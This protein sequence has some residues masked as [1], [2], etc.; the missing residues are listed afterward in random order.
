MFL[1]KTLMLFLLLT[2]LYAYDKEA[3]DTQSA[4]VFMYHRFGESAYPSTNIKVEQFAFH[5]EYLQKNDYNVWPLSK[6]IRYIIEKK[7]LPKKTV[8]LTIDDAYKSTYTHA[9]PM[10]KKKNF[11]F[12]VFVN[13][14]PVDQKSKSFMSWDQIREMRQN[15]AEFLNH[16]FSHDYL[17]PKKG[18]SEDGWKKRIG[19]EVQKAQKR[20]Q[21]E[22]GSDTNENPKILSYPFGEYSEQS[23]ELIASLGYIG[24]TQASGVMGHESD[25]KALC[26][27]PMA[28]DFAHAESFITK[29]NTLPLPV[30]SVHPFDPLLKAE[31]PPTLRIKLKRPLSQLG[32]YIASGEAIKVHWISQTEFEV[33][34]NRPLEAPRNRYACTAPAGEGKWYWFSHLWIIN[35]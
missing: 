32:C 6:V 8:S 26:R 33:R 30:E 24:V 19:D 34:A 4:V 18:E 31:N 14:A 10:L 9:Y 3:A 16:S 29:L 15:G 27:F 28:E 21:E 13:T 20:L 35:E 12:S 23:A 22:L 2:Q 11:P 17:I 5:L 1:K 25:L 7:P